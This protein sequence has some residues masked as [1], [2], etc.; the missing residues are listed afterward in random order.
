M[1]LSSAFYNFVLFFHPLPTL[2]L[3]VYIF[4]FINSGIRTVLAIE[5]EGEK[6]MKVKF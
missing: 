1:L 5:A 6:V 2:P 4:P 3:F